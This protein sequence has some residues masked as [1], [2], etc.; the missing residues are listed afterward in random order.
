M[1]RN[2]FKGLEISQLGFGMM[3][4]PILDGDYSKVDLETSAKMFETAIAA[5]VNYFDTAWAYHN[6]NSER[7]AGEIL[8]KYPRAGYFL[9]NKFPGYDASSYAK[10]EEIFE[11]QLKKCKTDYFDFYLMHNVDN[12]DI[13]NYLDEAKYGHMAY[14]RE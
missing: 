6:G 5:G 3:R 10:K 2:S 8:S 1:K 9:A 12:A 14:F 4:L 13:V 7:A 11:E